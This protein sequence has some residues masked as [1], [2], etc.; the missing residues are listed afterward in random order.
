MFEVRITIRDAIFESLNKK[1]FIRC[2]VYSLQLYLTSLSSPLPISD[3]VSSKILN[4]L[5]LTLTLLSL[6]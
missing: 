6:Q 4:N 5:S 1:S 2:S 3:D